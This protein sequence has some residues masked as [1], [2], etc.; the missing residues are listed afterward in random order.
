MNEDSSE[1]DQIAMKGPEPTGA[2][3]GPLPDPPH[4]DPSFGSLLGRGCL[5]LLGALIAAWIIL[6]AQEPWSM[7]H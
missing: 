3:V 2:P 5:L 1:A 6:A 7:G 4:N